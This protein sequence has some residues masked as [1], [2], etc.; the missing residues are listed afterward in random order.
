MFY[1]RTI[2]CIDLLLLN[3]HFFIVNDF[4][5]PTNI[6]EEGFLCSNNCFSTDCERHTCNN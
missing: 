3:N 2:E 5:Y 4:D 6:M 1:V